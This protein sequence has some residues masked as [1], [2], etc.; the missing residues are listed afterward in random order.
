MHDLEPFCG[1][2]TGGGLPTARVRFESDE[3]RWFLTKLASNSHQLLARRHPEDRIVKH[4]RA[5]N[6]RRITEDQLQAVVIGEI[7]TGCQTLQ[8]SHHGQAIAPGPNSTWLSLV[9]A[10]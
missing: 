9:E 10:H 2:E 5:T 7:M 4:R 1:N 8:V 6:E 3:N